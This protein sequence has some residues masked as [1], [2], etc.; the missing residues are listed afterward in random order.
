MNMKQLTELRERLEKRREELAAVFEKARAKDDAGND[1]LDLSKVDMDDA[2]TTQAKAEKIRQKN[3]EIDDLAKQVESLEGALQAHGQME[4]LEGFTHPAGKGEPDSASKG[5]NKGGEEYTKSLGEQITEHSVFKSWQGGAKHGQI[6]IDASPSEF[7]AKGTKTLF[8]TGAG[9]A[10]ESIRS[11]RV[12]EAAQQPISV[13]DILPMGTTS[14][15]AYVYMEETTRTHNAAETAEGVAYPE[16][17]FALTERSETVRKIADSVPV[18]D[19]QMEDVAGVQSYLDMRLRFGVRN[20]LDGQVLNG[21][22]VAPNLSGILDRAS[23]QTQAKG[24]DPT[25]DAFYKAMTK[26][27]VTGQAMPSAH[28]IHPNDWQQI[29][30]LRTADGIYIWG[31]PSEAGPERLW[32]LPVAQSQ[33]IAEGTGLTGDFANFSQ[34]F[35][36]RGIVVETGFVNDDFTKGQRT[37]RASGRW[38]LAVYRHEAFATVT[39]I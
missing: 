12:V 10:P 19:E 18:T 38:A 37:I 23:I 8:E 26:V 5:G 31:S 21:D 28:I 33:R 24:S 7:L 14:Q 6:V 25:P 27:R 17:A 22:G 32:G 39:G 2:T 35:E 11:G 9:W 3:A 20:R 16:S 1:V 15:A 4:S 29:R 30:L 34:L 13:L 36:R